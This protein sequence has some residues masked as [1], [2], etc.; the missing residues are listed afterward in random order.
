MREQSLYDRLY[1][2]GQSDA[3]PFHMP[4]HKRQTGAPGSEKSEDFGYAA[5]KNP[6]KMEEHGL[7]ETYAQL[8]WKIDIT[9]I[10]GFDNLHH[11][12]GILKESMELAAS[13]YG[14][15][16]T[17][18]SINGSTAGILSAICAVTKPGDT[19]LVARN[20]HKS[21]YHG[22]FLHQ[23]KPVYV[24]PQIDRQTGI[25][26][27]YSPEEIQNLLI[28]YPECK[29]VLITSPT[30]EG[31]ISDIK[32][33]AEIVHKKGIPLIVDEAHGAHLTMAGSVCQNFPVSATC[34]GADLVIQSL[35]KTLP[36]LTQTALLHVCRTEL[37]GQERYAREAAR[38]MGIFQTSS[39]SYVLM[40]S[41]DG[42]IR[43]LRSPQSQTDLQSYYE[44]L[45]QL[46]RRLHSYEQIHLLEPETMPKIALETTL[47]TTSEVMSELTGQ[48]RDPSKILLQANG[49]SGKELYDVLREKYA[50]QPEMCT[51]QY[52]LLMTS[53]Y[54]MEEMYDRLLGACDDM[55]LLCAGEKKMGV[56]A[57]MYCTSLTKENSSAM[58]ILSPSQM[59]SQ[60]QNLPK[61]QMIYTPA[62]A[63]TLETEEILLSQ[64]TGRISAE[65]A[66]QYPPG[67]PLLVPGEKVEEEVLRRLLG[68]AQAGISIQG[69]QSVDGTT[70]RVIKDRQFRGLQGEIR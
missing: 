57:Q 5:E 60:L 69:L 50:I 9:E 64:A 66:Y 42:C 56:A 17:L 37:N 54:D 52:V 49:M 62:E 43:Y 30:Y 70:I 14:T 59:L 61:P 63:D 26:C 23:L 16:K 55:E 10:D 1:E 48:Q 38:Y 7:Y 35:H 19:I 13:F 65:Y 2:Y 12:E 51:G 25:A 29:A 20:S 4:G 46:R 36:A 22:V 34:L 24:Y 32:A 8:P 53:V 15:E 28:Q 33:I 67:I 68:E 41:I 11:A 18:Y 31:V 3:V 27:G 40:A 21:V 45:E 44:R 47:E 58:Q 6:E 39:P